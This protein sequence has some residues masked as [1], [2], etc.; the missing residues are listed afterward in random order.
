MIE[1]KKK[2]KCSIYAN[3]KS[4]S[5]H[6]SEVEAISSYSVTKRIDSVFPY[7]SPYDGVLYFE[8]DTSV[9]RDIKINNI[10]ICQTSSS[11]NRALYSINVNKGDIIDVYHT[12]GETSNFGLM[13]QFYKERDL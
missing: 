4:E 3:G 11:G 1:F 10:K 12:S 8:M 5:D 7:T 13:A 9:N 6:L 2:I